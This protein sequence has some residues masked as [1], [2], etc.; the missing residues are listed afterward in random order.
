M[1]AQSR[2][3]PAILLTRPE[4]QSQ[5]F[6]AALGAALGP[7]VAGGIVISPLM[8][9]R[10]SQPLVPPGR[11]AALVLTSQA[12]AEAARRISAAGQVLPAR[13]YCVGDATAAAATAAGF[14]AISARGDAAALVAQLLKRSAP[15]PLLHLCGRDTAG[16]VAQSLSAGGIP[17]LA[18][19]CYEQVA[20]PLSASARTLLSGERPVL[21]PLFSTRSALLFRAAAPASPPPAAPLL[22]A[23]MSAAVAA[24]LPPLQPERLQIAAEPTMAAMVAAVA[25][26]HQGKTPA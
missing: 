22:V 19:L 5:Q 6:A 4:V 11:F 15:G 10:F 23:A 14:E 24:S 7:G 3:S 18:L 12:G 9:P 21:V 1:A 26:L 17:T 13:A 25:A 20:E 2:T 8:A 16:G